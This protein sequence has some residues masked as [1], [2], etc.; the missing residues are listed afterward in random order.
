MK[1]H[2]DRSQSELLAGKLNII[3]VT[4]VNGAGKTTS[5]GKL[6]Y[7]FQQM[8]KKVLIAP[9]DTFRAAALEQLSKWAQRAEV[10]IFKDFQENKITNQPK[11]DAVLYQ[12][13]KLA[14]KEKVEVL[15]VD[16][17][18]RLQNKKGLMD[19]LGKLSKVIDKHA[20]I[21]SRIQRLLVIDATTGQNGYNQAVLF[22]ETT[23][24]S[25]IILSKFDGSAKGGILFA[26]GHNLRIPVVYLGTGEGIEQLQ[27]FNSAEFVKTFD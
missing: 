2:N 24:L 9:C 7:R 27:I 8:G 19:E 25:G 20:P 23:K 15:I 11:T 26:I 10:S 14:E 3:L 16:T 18:G 17:A 5:I 4:G 22:N 6:A 21:D 13:L 12:S 1:I